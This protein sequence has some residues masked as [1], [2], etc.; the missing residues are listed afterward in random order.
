MHKK[1]ILIGGSSHAGKSTL[2]EALANRLGWKSLSTD[3][4]ARHPG[5]PW[6]HHGPVKEHVAQHYATLSGEELIADVLAHYRKNVLPQVAEMLAKHTSG[7][8]AG[9]LVLE[10]SALWPDD[11]AKL[12]L[13]GV[14]AIWLTAEDELFK[15]RI[16]AESR[17]ESATA[18]GRRLIEK[19]LERTLLYNRRMRAAIGRLGLPCISIEPGSTVEA[20][21][22]RCVGLLEGWDDPE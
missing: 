14:G 11:I 19:F 15:E 16:F 22:E 13:R 6:N 21:T 12:D 5:R 20:L 3:R 4:L 10:G 18:E 17:F 1:V 9:N 8:D 7:S 2:A